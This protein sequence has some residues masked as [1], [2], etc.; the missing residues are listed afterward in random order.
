MNWAGHQVV[1][2]EAEARI[3]PNAIAAAFSKALNRIV[4]AEIVPRGDWESMFRAQGMK[5][6][7]PRMQMLQRRLDRLQGPRSAFEKQSDR[8]RPNRLRSRFKARQRRPSR[9]ARSS[10]SHPRGQPLAAETMQYRQGVSGRPGNARRD[11]AEEL[12]RAGPR[13]PACLG[14]KSG[15]GRAVTPAAILNAPS[16]SWLTSTKLH[17]RNYPQHHL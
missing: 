15:D 9:V 10:Q 16:R 3:S 5:N 11:E 2:L 12:T 6:P 1:E 7:T 14:D 4:K 8:H 13:R 17:S